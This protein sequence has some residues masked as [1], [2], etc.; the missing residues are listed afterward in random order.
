M[1]YYA[2]INSDNVV[3]SVTQ[4]NSEL[5]LSDK[6]IR[7]SSLDYSILGKSYDAATS[8]SAGEPVFMDAPTLPQQ[9]P[10]LEWL[11]D[12]GPFFDRFG[13]AKVAVLTSSDVG[14]KAILADTQVRKWIDLKRPDVTQSIAYIASVVPSLTAELQDS[15]LNTAVSSEENLA[16]RRVFFS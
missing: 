7:I 1:P 16:L 5:P 4:T 15:I 6:L 12:I 2:Q 14:V 10:A 13:A 9:A 11:I 3:T 8:T